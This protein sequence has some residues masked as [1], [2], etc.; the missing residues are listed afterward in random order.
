MKM[1]NKHSFL[2]FILYTLTC[3]CNGLG[4]L[5][6]DKNDQLAE[7]KILEFSGT[8]KSRILE[9]TV[10]LF[11]N[12]KRIA[13]GLV[14][15]PSGLFLTKASAS[16]G[17]TYAKSSTGEKFPVRIRKRDKFTDLALLQIPQSS[18][19]WPLIDWMVDDNRTV[20][21]SWVTTASP[22][23]ESVYLSILSG[24]PREIHRE[25]GV[26]GV[27]LGDKGDEPGIPVLEVIP[28]SAADRG[29]LQQKDL[30]LSVD[31]RKVFNSQEVYNLLNEK[32]PGDL[33]LLKAKRRENEVEMRI[34][35]GHRSVTFDLF[36]RNLLIS[37]PVSKRKDGF[38]MVLQHD[39]P[40]ER[41]AMG[42][43]LFAPSGKCIGINVARVDRVTTYA[44]PTSIIEP[45]VIK[46]LNSMLPK[47]S[48]PDKQ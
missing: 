6:K 43:G 21:G 1:P 20:E 13:L 3:S 36:N 38:P 22:T 2:I 40:L 5:K 37:G 30:L 32:D 4:I 25:G 10:S 31:G 11:R 7:K 8:S 26:M 15:D 35:L 48:E 19:D 18:H 46:W 29:G 24:N 23:L 42:G 34:T 17:A 14:V 28:Y 33:I 45:I 12:N 27:I 39:A 16:V 44:L 47:T 9:S 41:T